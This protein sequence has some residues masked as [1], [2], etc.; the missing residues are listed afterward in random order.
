M[1]GDNVVAL[2]KLRP[3]LRTIQGLSIM[4]PC[5]YYRTLPYDRVTTNL[6]RGFL[7]YVVGT[8]MPTST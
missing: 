8:L 6:H 3:T 1:H 2:Y 4:I 7:H 5:I